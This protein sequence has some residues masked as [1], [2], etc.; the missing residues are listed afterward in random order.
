MPETR[1]YYH[2]SD[3]LTD[4]LVGSSDGFTIPF[5]IIAGMTGA[6]LSANAII[7]AG[8]A[9]AIIGGIAMGLSA[10][11]GEKEQLDETGFISPRE[12]EILRRIGIGEDI[13][14]QL[15]AEAARDKSEFNELAANYDLPEESALGKIRMS[16]ITVGL[17]Y[18]IGGVIP[19]I[20]FLIID[21]LMTAL[22]YSGGITVICLFVLGFYRA[23]RTDRN[24]WGGAFRPIFLTLASAWGAYYVAHLFV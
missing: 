17:S 22:F 16:A 20:P 23:K 6:M 9:A 8:F 10:Y 12:E 3:T 7:I 21:D 11:M 13:K 2:V 1:H 14:E 18:F 5:V 15:A 24:G 19:I 4:I